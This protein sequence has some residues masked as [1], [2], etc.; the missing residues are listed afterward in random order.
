[1]L[2][3]CRI[4]RR[5]LN[6][7]KWWALD[8]PRQIMFAHVLNID[9]KCS[10]PSSSVWWFRGPKVSP[11]KIGYVN[12]YIYIYVFAWH[13]VISNYCILDIFGTLKS[14]VVIDVFIVELQPKSRDHHMVLVPEIRFFEMGS[15]YFQLF[16]CPVLTVTKEEKIRR[17]PG[18][19]RSCC[20]WHMT[21]EECQYIGDISW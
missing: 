21:F 13:T 8:L 10:K 11:W 7:F 9:S 2:R 1:M 4:S 17:G 12:M 14:H 16:V 3:T 20:F 19:Y 5:L 6:S 18:D 15:R